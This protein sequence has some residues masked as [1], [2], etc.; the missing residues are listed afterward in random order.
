MGACYI[1]TWYDD[2][3]DGGILVEV[4]GT[5]FVGGVGNGCISGLAIVTG[6]SALKDQKD[7]GT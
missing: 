2:A 6:Q 3:H 1:Q 4:Y 5:I 7:T